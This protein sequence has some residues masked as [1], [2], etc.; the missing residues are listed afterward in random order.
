MRHGE[1]LAAHYASGD[2][3]LFPSLTE[4]YGNVTVEALASGLAVVAY[5]YAAAA[6]HIRHSKSGL[7]APFG[8]T[9]TFVA[10]AAALAADAARMRCLGGA[11]REH[12]LAHDWRRVVQELEAVLEAAADG[13]TEARA[14]GVLG[15]LAA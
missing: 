5:D 10:L 6:A 13:G 8:D 3:F 2:I 12:A 14:A 15:N 1:D 11:A 9:A 4:T 7:L